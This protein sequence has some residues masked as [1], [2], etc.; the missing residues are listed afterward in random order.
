LPADATAD[1]NSPATRAAFSALFS[2]SPPV[3]RPERAL[4]GCFHQFI[5]M[6]SS[7]RARVGIE[8]FESGVETTPIAFLELTGP[9]SHL[10]HFEAGRGTADTV[11][12]TVRRSSRPMAAIENIR[13]MEAASKI[14]AGDVFQTPAVRVGHSPTCAFPNRFHW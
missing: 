5:T 11:P 3:N 1:T 8:R 4:I 9:V 12:G 14:M 13:S 2:E 10:V 6:E 7:H